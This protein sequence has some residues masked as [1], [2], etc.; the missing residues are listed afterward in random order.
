MILSNIR[1]QEA[2]D[3][4]RLG[5]D[6]Q[7]SPRRQ[8]PDQACHFQTTAVELRLLLF[9]KFPSRALSNFELPA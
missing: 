1:L 4:G 8:T 5:I 6:P 9:G 2:L 3:S 7:P